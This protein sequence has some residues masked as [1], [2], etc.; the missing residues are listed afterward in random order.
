MT[1]KDYDWIKIQEYYDIGHSLRDIIKHFNITS[2][3][4]I[5]SAKSK[6]LFITRK[7][8]YSE[9]VRNRL[10]NNA[11][12]FYANEE[13]RILQSK[14][15][16]EAVLANPDS[17][18]ANNV[19]GRVKN[20]EFMGKKLKGTWELLVAQFLQDNN[21]KW[22]IVSVPFP[23]MWEDNWHL[24]FPDFYLPELDLYLEVK[25]FERERDKC[26][27][28]SIKNLR[29]IRNKE[30]KEIKNGTFRIDNIIN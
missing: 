25:G 23:Y 10:S 18:N 29:I 11:K 4:I 17:Y 14:A 24:Y 12:N 28:K 27:W 19:C 15:M 3:T 21:I 13:N 7:N 5:Y 22:D 8:G 26:K 30:I 2:T 9:I 6:G 20:V 1:Y 16:K